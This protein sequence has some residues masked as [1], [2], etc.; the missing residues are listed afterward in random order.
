MPSSTGTLTPSAT[1]T[2][3][4]TPSP[5]ITPTATITF[6]PTPLPPL[7]Q[8]GNP[9][10]IALVPGSPDLTQESITQL[11]MLIDLQTEESVLLILVQDYQEVKEM[12]CRQEIQA[13]ILDTQTYLE[14]YAEGCAAVAFISEIDGKNTKRSQFLTYQQSGISS[15]DG[16]NAK[17]ICRS[18]A[19]SWDT[20]LLPAET[21]K[22]KGYDPQKDFSFV[23]K[24]ND[25]TVLEG[26]LDHECDL[27]ITRGG[28][29]ETNPDLA[30]SLKLIGESPPIPNPNI[31]FHPEVPNKTEIAMINVIFV[32][33]R[34]SDQGQKLIYRMYG[35]DDLVYTDNSFYNLMWQELTP[36]P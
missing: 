14:A 31:S 11:S 3:S 4:I 25:Q 1:I 9:I 6:T 2:A 10:T 16:L 7:G 33:R 27:G 21:L 13:G 30:D 18:Q 22:L 29:L 36:Q 32:L 12:L 34:Y 23:Q 28:S 5:S 17:S 24:E 15:F 20:W 19:D 35:W 26:L 8:P